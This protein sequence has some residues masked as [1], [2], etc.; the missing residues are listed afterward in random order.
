MEKMTINEI[1]AEY[2]N[3]SAMIAQPHRIYRIDGAG[4]RYYY[5][6]DE[7]GEPLFY[8]SVTTMLSN[9]MPRNKM[10]EKWMVENFSSMEEHR[11][12]LDEKADYGT[13][14]HCEI[15]RLLIANE[16]DLDQMEE[17]LEA[18]MS[19]NN[20]GRECYSWIPELKKDLLSFAQFVFD[21][22]VEPVAVEIVLSSDKL[23][24]AGA[25]DLVCY[26]NF[27]KKRVLALVDNKSGRK[28]F[29]ESH[30]LQ[31]H[32]YAEM[33]NEHFPE[34]PIEMVFNWSPKDW[35]GETP[36]YKFKNQTDSKNA[37]KLEYYIALSKLDNSRKDKAVVLTGG[38][39]DLNSK[40]IENN[41][42]MI[43]LT[44]Y[45][46]EHARENNKAGK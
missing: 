38:K 20:L 35:R 11:V 16:I 13:F 44:T 12:F 3:P 6:F 36:T 19:E 31:L 40:S 15:N 41:I 32:A 21:K 18:F 23:E 4:G 2:I 33:W 26:L 39:I 7:E 8:T 37:K 28:G 42:R 17:R 1:I 14:M 27:G 30:E 22:E 46:K 24:L 5:R 34:K 29:H 25:L 9:Q 10:L 43:D 45:A